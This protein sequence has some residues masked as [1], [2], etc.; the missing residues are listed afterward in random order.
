MT[1]K[2]P[3]TGSGGWPRPD[4]RRCHL[5]ERTTGRADV[6]EAGRAGLEQTGRGPPPGS[7]GTRSGPSLYPFAEGKLPPQPRGSELA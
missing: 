3:G 7:P 6:S 1:F 2:G 5:A 4:V